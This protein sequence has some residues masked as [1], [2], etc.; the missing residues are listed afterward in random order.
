MGE[1]IM[2]TNAILSEK[3]DIPLSKIRRWT[4]EL[5]PPDP[6]ATRRSGYKREFSNNDGFFIY[7]GGHMVSELGFT[8]DGARKALEI[9][10]DWL[11]FNGLVPDIPDYAHRV[12]VNREI[13]G[14]IRVSFFPATRFKAKV[15]FRVRGVVSRKF[16]QKDDSM[17]GL[18]TRHKIE[19]VE[20]FFG[21]SFEDKQI[22]L[23]YTDMEGAQTH[24]IPK[25]LTITG[26][27]SFF[28][29]HVLGND[30]WREKWEALL[31]KDPKELEKMTRSDIE[32]DTV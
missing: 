7:L 9:L 27:L 26:M 16:T 20:Y 14:G 5:L 15:M 4:K 1:L 2:L 6:K 23:A 25:D 22:K 29:K 13:T 30:N 31:E 24:I 12:G 11:L 8:F 28:N 17:W 32:K 10:T 18:Y 3:L 19:S 21:P